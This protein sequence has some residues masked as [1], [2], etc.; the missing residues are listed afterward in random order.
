MGTEPI[1]DIMGEIGR[2]RRNNI[3]GL[4]RWRAT[5]LDNADAGLGSRHWWVS[6]TISLLIGFAAVWSDIAG[7]AR[8]DVIGTRWMV[9]SGVLFFLLTRLRQ[10]LLWT[11]AVS[12]I[13]SALVIGW[14]V[15]LRFNTGHWAHQSIRHLLAPDILLIFGDGNGA[16]WFLNFEP[17]AALLIIAVTSVSVGLILTWRARNKSHQTDN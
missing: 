1:K 11:A 15:D 17:L 10:T 3:F 13:S 5:K 16:I 8:V 12:G 7:G 14:K 6:A 9:V 4:R 2:R